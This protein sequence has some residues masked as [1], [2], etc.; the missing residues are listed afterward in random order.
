[1]CKMS[2]K[3]LY[4]CE[5]WEGECNIGWQGVTDKKMHW[6]AGGWTRY[7]FVVRILLKNMIYDVLFL[8]SY[9]KLEEAN[10]CYLVRV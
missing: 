4:I 5:I 10:A 6:L 7:D 3:I 8:N 2:W 9:P 1:M